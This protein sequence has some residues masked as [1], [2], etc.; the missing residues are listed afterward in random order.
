MQVKRIAE[1]SEGSILQYIQ[2][3][4][5]YHLSLRSFFVSI[6]E[7]PLKT[8]FAVTENPI[9]AASSCSYMHI[10]VQVGTPLKMSEQTTF[11][12]NGRK[13]VKNKNN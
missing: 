5:S 9:L 6:F 12:V 11:V 4:L 1:C 7:W 10:C 8:C 13:M 2:P 3:L